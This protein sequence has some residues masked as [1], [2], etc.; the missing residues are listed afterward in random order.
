MF[1]YA[2]NSVR[3]N[4]TF[5]GTYT[6]NSMGDFLLGYINNTSTSQQQVDTIE[7]RVYDA[8]IQDDWK[9]T[10]KLTLNFGLRYELP[11][12]FVEE[13]DRQSNFVLDSGPCYAQL[14]T[15][16][17]RSR[18]GVGR[19]LVHTDYNN[20]APRLGLAYQASSKTVI[21]SGFGIFYGRDA[22]LGIQRRPPNHPPFITSATFAGDQTNP[23]FLLRNGFPANAL[24][25][26]AGGIPDGDTFPFDFPT[27]YAIQWNINV[28]RELP[29][30]FLAQVGYTGS[31]AHKLPGVIA[32]N[33]AF[34]GTRNVNARRPYQG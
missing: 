26:T 6:G 4:F 1:V 5:N 2:T 8:Y 32:V 16:A 12:P 31:E 3:P 28:Q 23:A 30:S 27:P 11:T 20:F 7:Q 19:A 21:R 17:D 18:C 10:S 34:P 22:D 24:N 14:I 25:L 9:A 13:F 33:Q 15:V 29:G